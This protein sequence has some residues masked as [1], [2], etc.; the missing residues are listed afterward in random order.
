M[1]KHS[2]IKY[3]PNLSIKDNAAKNGC[4]VGATIY[5]KGKGGSATYWVSSEN[6]T[7]YKYALGLKRGD[8]VRIDEKFSK[9][10]DADNRLAT[11]LNRL[12]YPI[13]LTDEAR[14]KYI[15]WLKRNGVTIAGE[16]IEKGDLAGLMGYEQYGIIT[17]NNIQKLIDLATSKKKV[18][19]SAYLL[20][21][22]SKL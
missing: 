8:F 19:I 11:V 21:Q 9:L 3:N 22:K 6:E 15:A 10:K 17:K 16:F 12:N 4:T 14:D 20:E 7:Q 5:F 2:P 1:P 18:E 13:D